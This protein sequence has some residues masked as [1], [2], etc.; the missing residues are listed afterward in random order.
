MTYKVNKKRTV[1]NETWEKNVAI[2]APIIVF[3]KSGKTDRTVNY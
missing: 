3:Y 1:N 2:P